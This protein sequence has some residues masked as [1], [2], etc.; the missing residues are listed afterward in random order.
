[1]KNSVYTSIILLFFTTFSLQVNAQHFLSTNGQAIVNENGD[2]ILLRG[3]GLGGWMVQE[4]YMLQTASFANPQHKIR[5]KIEE[6]IGEADTDLFYDAWLANHARK[7][8]VDSLKSW[9]FNSVRL[10][11]H[12][13]LFTLPIEEEPVPGQN[14]WLT[15]GFELTDSLISWCKQ[16][17]MYVVLDLHAAP[18]GQGY[19]AGISD[20]DDTKPSLWE[21][22]ANRDKMVALWK[23]LAER[24]A[25]EQWV[26]GYD[27]LNEPNWDLPGGIALRNLYWEVTDSIRAV[28]PNHIIF[29]EG[30]WFAND[31]TGLTPPWDDNMVYSPH[32]YWSFN[33]EATMKWVLDM[34]EAYNVPLYLGESGENS[35]VWFRDAIRLMEDLG[36]GWA[37]W[38]LKKVESIAGPLAVIKTPGYQALLDYWN[39][40]GPT[41][42]VEFARA[43]LMDIAE[44]GLKVENCVFQKDVI[45]AMFRQ[46]YS[47][48]T[49]PFTS[50]QI[51]G[52][53]HASDFDLGVI[54]QA[55]YDVESANYSVSSGTY[56]PWNNG[57]VYRNDAIDIERCSDV[58]NANGYNVGFMD[59]GEWMQYET[60]STESGVYEIRVRAASGSSGGQ[61]H[62]ASGK[63][64]ITPSFFAAGTGGWQS[65]K[66]L[67]IPNVILD[68]SDKKI[69]FYVDQSGFNVS[70]F[71]FV[72]TGTSTTSIPTQFVAAVTVDEYTIQMNANKFLSSPLP[73]S[74]GGFSIMVNGNFIPITAIE[75]DPD[76]PRVINFS[77][78]YL[79]KSTDVIRISYAGSEVNAAD[80]TPLNN[81]IQR[82]VKNTLEFVHQI[83]GRI[84]AEA[85]SFQ[86]GVAL[87]TTT[88]VGG[89]QNIGFLDPGDYLDYEINVTSAGVY[90]VSYRTAS[91]GGTGGLQL[92]LVNQNGDV[93]VLHS[94]T[95][96]PTGGWQT[97]TTT[98]VNALLP[99]GR[100]VLRI[101]IT[102]AP[103][104]INWLEFSKVTSTDTPAGQSFK[105]VKVFPNPG[106]GVFNL[107]AALEKSQ[108]VR[109]EVY[110]FSGNLLDVQALGA[111]SEIQKTVSLQSFPDGMYQ[112]VIRLEDGTYHS[113]KLVKTAR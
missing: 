8:D 76:N 27:L 104:N 57:W 12:Y 65:W 4:G 15:K 78:S 38:P 46:V 53:I 10:P 74:P 36:I 111:V 40:S 58:I 60:E 106:S 22:K 13:N 92:Q 94:P 86:S 110:N 95:F 1:M 99:P 102:Q 37:W 26:A 71:E 62:F 51:P 9:G 96:A 34:R 49:L 20:Y 90:S 47:D 41:P 93:T 81:F 98:S 87:E 109:L 17:E 72:K 91:Q 56:T 25:N 77:V 16:N 88:D 61:F 21:S 101:L 55:Y 35:N 75:I 85:F 79:L 19:D 43:A 33:D 82:D 39:G 28:D 3:M 73:T 6:L 32:K 48:E 11:M 50:H 45:D 100:H 64:D 68:E 108:D 113:S 42:S 89:G 5:A 29:I 30:N 107:H 97:W 84:E 83:P 7:A 103:F 14:T 31:V 23:R 70:S 105:D 2:T 80:G 52:I 54:G 66:T 69:R 44:N 67:V 63:A 24:Y 59:T 112:L 18:G